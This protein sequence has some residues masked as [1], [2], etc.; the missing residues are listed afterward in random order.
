[1][2]YPHSGVM[3][4]TREEGL[5]RSSCRNCPWYRTFGTAEANRAAAH[6]HIRRTG[7]R[8]L[9]AVERIYTYGP[10]PQNVT[11]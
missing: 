6:R 8:V 2:M 11:D 9:V 3:T 10:T 1:M 7:H 5:V 4:W